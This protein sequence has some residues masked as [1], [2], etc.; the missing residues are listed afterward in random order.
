[1]PGV[2]VAG[3]DRV[4]LRR[5]FTVEEYHYMGRAGILHENERVEL[6]DG[7]VIRVA[8]IGSRH[9]ASVNRLTDWITPRVTGRAIVSIQ[10][11]VRLSEHN[12]PRPDVALF[13]R[14]PDFY[15]DGIP[16]PSDTLLIIEVADSSLAYDREVKLPRYAAAGIP[17][18]WLVDLEAERVTVH[19][20]PAGGVYQLVTV[21]ARGDSLM[22]AAFPDLIIPI[23][24]ILGV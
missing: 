12:E 10:N 4:V 17:E 18:V 14:R 22:P 13:R 20:D 19:R 23:D 7:E 11:P 2:G 16:G 3:M 24:D 1:M 21:H 5:R 8:A 6:I 15:A 9:R